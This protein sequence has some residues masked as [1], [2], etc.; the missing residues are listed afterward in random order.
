MTSQ[1]N[2]FDVQNELLKLAFNVDK[3]TSL[4]IYKRNLNKCKLAEDFIIKFNKDNNN[5][6]LGIEYFQIPINGVRQPINSCE[7][8]MTIPEQKSMLVYLKEKILIH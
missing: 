1:D 8:Y 3:E 4:Q 5:K 2:P 7:V 6:K